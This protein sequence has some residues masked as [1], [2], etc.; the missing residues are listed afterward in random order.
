MV[1]HVSGSYGSDLF[2]FMY[3]DKVLFLPSALHREFQRIKDL[4]CQSQLKMGR[5]AFPENFL[6]NIF[7]FCIVPFLSAFF[8]F[9]CA[10]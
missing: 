3:C 1:L 7:P 8:L 9:L 6:A 10:Y 2:R 5:K 4:P